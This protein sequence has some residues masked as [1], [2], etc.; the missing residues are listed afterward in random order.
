MALDVSDLG[1]LNPRAPQHGCDKDIPLQG[2]SSGDVVEASH[3]GA[4]AS[5]ALPERR[6]SCEGVVVTQEQAAVSAA[7]VQPASNAVGEFGGGVVFHVPEDLKRRIDA[8]QAKK[9]VLPRHQQDLLEGLGSALGSAASGN[10]QYNSA[11]RRGTAGNRVM[12]R[13]VSSS[14]LDRDPKLSIRCG[15]GPRDSRR[16]SGGTVHRNRRDHECLQKQGHRDA[17]LG[18]VAVAIERR[19]RQRVLSPFNELQD[20]FE[21]LEAEQRRMKREHEQQ[22]LNIESERVKERRDHQAQVLRLEEA[23]LAQGMRREEELASQL[24]HL[25]K[26]WAEVQA[27]SARLQAVKAEEM[28]LALPVSSRGSLHQSPETQAPQHRALLPSGASPLLSRSS[29]QLPEVLSTASAASLAH[30][31]A[32]VPPPDCDVDLPRGGGEPSPPSPPSSLL[33]RLPQGMPEVYEAAI[34]IILKHGWDALHGGENG[35]PA[36]TALHWAAFEGRADICELLLA[37]GADSSHPDEMGKTALDYALDGGARTAAAATLLAPVTSAVA[38]AAVSR[39]GGCATSSPS[40]S[41]LWTSSPIG[42]GSPTGMHLSQPPSGYSRAA[43]SATSS[44]A[45][46]TWTG[47]EQRV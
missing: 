31:R 11:R 6:R 36:W 17:E 39:P 45:G 34:A 28:R 35:H 13:A 19:L 30:Q 8:L 42:R 26:E 18:M 7:S 15:A 24:E 44:V 38:S 4:V 16:L 12:G 2:K 47:D 29:P 43:W 40:I 5:N 41:S 37:A 25:D 32:V 27:A 33:S 3:D 14:A 10:P 23:L 1:L 20:S 9:Q 22:L 46:P 21:V